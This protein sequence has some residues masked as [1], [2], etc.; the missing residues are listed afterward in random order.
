VI[1]R[2]RGLQALSRT[3]ARKSSDRIEM[4]GLWSP[5]A[6]MMSTISVETTARLTWPPR[7][8]AA[9]LIG[10][11]ETSNYANVD[12]A[13]RPIADKAEAPEAEQHQG[14][15]GWFG[16][17]LDH[18]TEGKDAKPIDRQINVGS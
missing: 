14:P 13:F 8:S 17:R 7:L 11:E 4:S 10:T 15:R 6:F 3:S 16:N 5:A 2:N 1:A 9:L 18:A 12:A